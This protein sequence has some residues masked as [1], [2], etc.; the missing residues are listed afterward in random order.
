MISTALVRAVQTLSGAPS[1]I[2]INRWGFRETGVGMIAVNASVLLPLWTRR[3]WHRGGGA[4]ILRQPPPDPA[5]PPSPRRPRVPPGAK[6]DALWLWTISAVS[7]S[8]NRTINRD[9][10]ADPSARE[11]DPELGG[12]FVRREEVPEKQASDMHTSHD[13]EASGG[14][15]PDAKKSGQSETRTSVFMEHEEVAI[16]R[17][18]HDA[19]D[20][21]HVHP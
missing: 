12:I 15:V 17:P 20:G 11:G 4:H 2:N 3:F 16:P 7:S 19:A 13:G 8:G 6:W 21:S 1:V 9:G 5:Q 10:G 18:S 14:P